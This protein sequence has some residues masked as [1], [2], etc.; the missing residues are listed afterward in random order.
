MKTFI[1]YV[2]L[3][4]PGWALVGLLLV[5]LWPKTGWDPR[6]AA[7]GFAVYVLKDFLLYP[8]FR[9]AYEGEA[10]TGGAQLIGTA[11]VAEQDLDP[12]GYVAVAGER[13]KA[14]VVPGEGWIPRG[15]PVRIEGAA[16]LALRV[17]AISCPAGKPA[18]FSSRHSVFCPSCG[19]RRI[20]SAS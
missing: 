20:T 11:G 15:T 6:L 5:W 13:W 10:P 12:D 18:S 1:K 2:A 3:Q 19:G 17:A 8:F 16:G 4:L 9:S 14:A 7:V